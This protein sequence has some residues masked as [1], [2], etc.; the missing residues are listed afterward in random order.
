MQKIHTDTKKKITGRC[1][2]QGQWTG[3]LIFFVTEIFSHLASFFSCQKAF[4]TNSFS[5]KTAKICQNLP[6]GKPHTQEKYH[7]TAT[8]MKVTMKVFTG[9]NLS[10]MHCAVY[11][12]QRTDLAYLTVLSEP[13]SKDNLSALSQFLPNLGSGNGGYGIVGPFLVLSP[14]LRVWD[15]GYP[16]PWT[17]LMVAGLPP[18]IRVGWGWG[19][20]LAG[21]SLVLCPC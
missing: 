5:L 9:L 4:Q 15:E 16:I 7:G 19:V 3:D 11:Y 14:L 21:S 13:T 1:D 18:S 12:E 2:F 20:W 6:K 17:N 8:Y 10:G